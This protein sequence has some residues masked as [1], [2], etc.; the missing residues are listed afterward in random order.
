MNL[1]DYRPLDHSARETVREFTH[2]MEHS[3]TV[4]EFSN[5]KVFEEE[6]VKGEMPPYEDEDDLD[7]LQKTMVIGEV[8]IPELAESMADVD[9]DATVKF[10]FSGQEDY[11]SIL[12]DYI[13]KYHRFSLGK[14]N[15]KENPFS[16][17]DVVDDFLTDDVRR[18]LDPPEVRR[19]EREKGNYIIEDYF[20]KGQSDE[21]NV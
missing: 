12:G 16:Q 18:L 19:R 11:N 17:I 15:D 3:P 7:L 8:G 4:Y 5:F 9:P 14:K 1:E 6:T 21:G 2:L 10:K 20:W 13:I